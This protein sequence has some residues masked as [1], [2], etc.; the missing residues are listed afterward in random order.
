M[1]LFRGRTVVSVLL[2]LLFAYVIHLAGE[3]FHRPRREGG[4]M[5][6]IKAMLR[7]SL[8]RIYGVE[9]H[10]LEHY[11][12][13]GERVLIIANHT[14]YL[15]ALQLYAFV[16]DRLSFAVNT[17]VAKR[18]WVRLGLL[19]VEFLPNGSRQSLV[20]EGAHTSPARQPQGRDLS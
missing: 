1:F 11:R 14:S 6:P 2:P 7:W 15:D 20:G 16:P 3:W 10:G 5:H 13:A 17:L 18:W 4:A 19:F 12:A 9:V 8:A